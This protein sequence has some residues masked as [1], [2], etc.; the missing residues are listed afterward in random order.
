MFDY[1]S[2]ILATKVDIIAAMIDN[3]SSMIFI[4]YNKSDARKEECDKIECCARRQKT[5]QKIRVYA[6]SSE[7]S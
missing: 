5:E 6:R 7:E 3:V 2:R 1:Q 4:N